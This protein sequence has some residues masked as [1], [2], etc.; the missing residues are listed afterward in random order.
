MIQDKV[1]I[2]MTKITLDTAKQH[3]YY[4]RARMMTHKPLE[5]EGLW[6]K[7]A[8]VNL[9]KDM[10]NKSPLGVCAKRVSVPHVI[11]SP[12]GSHGAPALKGKQPT[13]MDSQGNLLVGVAAK[14]PA[15]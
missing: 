12:A 10:I 2:S 8:V 13:E 9:A 7:K 11:L 1:E 15:Y 14:V 5:E 3:T 4:W 6:G